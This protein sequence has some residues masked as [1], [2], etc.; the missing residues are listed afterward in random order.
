MLIQRERKRKNAY[1]Q[2]GGG[3]NERSNA[4]GLACKQLAVDV[5][6]FISSIG[7]AV[8]A[9]GCSEG[10]RNLQPTSGGMALGCH[11]NQAKK[12]VKRFRKGATKAW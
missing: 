4:V 3:T 11:V 7:C 9:E 5:A 1:K 8:S 10:K 12:R 2:G 6:V